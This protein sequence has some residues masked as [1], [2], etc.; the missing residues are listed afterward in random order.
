LLTCFFLGKHGGALADLKA[1]VKLRLGGKCGSGKQGIS[2]IHEDDM[3]EIIL[4][5]ITDEKFHGPYIASSP[6][7]V[8]NEVFMRELRAAMK[9]KIGLPAPA[10]MVK[11]GAKYILRTDPELALLGRY[12]VP[13]KLIKEGFEFKFPELK[14]CLRNLIA[15]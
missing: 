13:G 2:W 6:N 8:S 11:L 7:P 5:C 9:I 4:R 1:I 10:F 15:N 3:N 12:I 14:D